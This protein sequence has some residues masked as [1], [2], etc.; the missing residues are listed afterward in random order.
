MKIDMITPMSIFRDEFI[1]N[2]NLTD[3]LNRSL[4]K[5]KVVTDA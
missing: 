1:T 3:I 2:G 5:T 4:D